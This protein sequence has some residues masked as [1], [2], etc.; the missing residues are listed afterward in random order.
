MNYRVIRDNWQ[1]FYSSLVG[2]THTK[3]YRNKL[4][5]RRNLLLDRASIDQLDRIDPA[6]LAMILTRL[7]YS[8]AHYRCYQDTSY[9][10]SRNR[11][12]PKI[13]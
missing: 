1:L 8:P 10:K 9:I 3:I 11:K 4:H 12:Y 2:L 5:T 13:N 6:D 7:S